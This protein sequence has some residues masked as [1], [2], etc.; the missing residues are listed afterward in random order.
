METQFD[1][2]SFLRKAVEQKASDI[3]LRVGDRP[4]V[5][6]GGVILKTDLPILTNDD[7]KAVAN[8]IIPERSKPHI[9]TIYELDFSYMIEDCSRFRVNFCKQM[10]NYS[11]V[12]RVV[13]FEVPCF[14]DLSLPP[15][16]EKF[17]KLNNGI[18]LITGPTG[19]GKTTTIA[20]LLDFINTHQQKHLITIEDPIEFVYTNKKSILT[21]RQLGLDT[22]SFPDGV[23]YALRQDPDI[24]L[25]GEMRDR[26]TITSALKAAE[27][28]H[29][30]FSTLH[31]TDAIQ[32]INRLINAFEPHERDA[33]KLQISATLR[34]TVAQK[35][36]PKAD[37]SGMVPATE[38]LVVT[39]AIKNYIEKEELDGIYDLIKNNNFNEMI[40]MNM[41]LYRLVKMDLVTQDIA[42]D[43]SDNKAELAQLFK[44]AYSGADYGS[45]R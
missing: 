21:Q 9:E 28:G 10:G 30:V 34:G 44:G 12:I 38:V 13:P 41:S 37:G 26:E 18:V 42:L 29:L 11:F 8:S 35:L 22:A 33:L 43:Y 27:T 4:S 3:H 24:I 45:D 40:T 20:S 16:I 32:T 39:P 31:T 2:N 23:K 1:I 25:I 5:R 36:L 15:S 17:T 6:K 14:T 19:S 7:L